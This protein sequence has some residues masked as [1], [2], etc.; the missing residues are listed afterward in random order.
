MPDAYQ[1]KDW[2]KIFEDANSRKR[3]GP[4]NRVLVATKHD[5][6]GMKRLMLRE[7]A[8]R[9]YGAWMILVQLAAKCPTR[10]VLADD[11]GPLSLQ[12]IHLKTG[13]SEADIQHAL[14]IL[15]A[16]P[17]HWLT[18]PDTPS[19]ELPRS[20]PNPVEGLDDVASVPGRL[21]DDVVS[22]LERLSVHEGL[23]G[24]LEPTVSVSDVL[25][26]WL[27]IDRG[28]AGAG[29]TFVRLVN[30]SRV[31][32]TVPMV[33]SDLVAA[34]DARLITSIDGI[35]ISGKD[36]TYDSAGVFANGDLILEPHEIGN[37]ELG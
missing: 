21:T 24:R 37:V 2:S 13:L 27:R 30:D 28:R 16:G 14:S 33:F 15:S 6:K 5:G 8:A 36:L 23:W 32:S 31:R 26:G 18:P 10:G 3:R 20:K 7:D 17:F 34:A 4:M 25:N 11:D 22:L 29:E 1:I 9:V 19:R 12:D 35:D